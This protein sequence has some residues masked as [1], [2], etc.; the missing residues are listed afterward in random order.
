MG[1]EEMQER[2]GKISL[3]IRPLK[4]DSGILIAR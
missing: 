3:N 4:S 1:Y 2:T